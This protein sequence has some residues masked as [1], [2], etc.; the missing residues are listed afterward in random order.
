[1]PPSIRGRRQSDVADRT[2]EGW[3]RHR[4]TRAATVAAWEHTVTV[5]PPEYPVNVP[6]LLLTLSGLRRHINCSLVS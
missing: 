2:L 6:R 5:W 3:H 1:M 4:I